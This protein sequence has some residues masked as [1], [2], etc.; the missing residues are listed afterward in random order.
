MEDAIT[1]SQLSEWVFGFLL[2]LLTLFVTAL[3]VWFKKINDK[4]DSMDSTISLKLEKYVPR[5]EIEEKDKRIDYVI[6]STNKEISEIKENLKTD[7]VKLDSTL[8]DIFDE[9]K[10]LRN[11]VISRR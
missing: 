10:E 6:Q 3:G 2:T 7:A 8:K 5:T 4:V 1:T 9:I 11:E